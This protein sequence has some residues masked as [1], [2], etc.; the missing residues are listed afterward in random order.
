M[1][2]H[3]GD[4][5]AAGTSFDRATTARADPSRDPDAAIDDGPVDGFDDF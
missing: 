2:Q 5:P 4:G 3:A 1:P